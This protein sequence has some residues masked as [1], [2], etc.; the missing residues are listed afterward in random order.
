MGLSSLIKKSFQYQTTLPRA[1]SSKN[2]LGESW[3]LTT[4]LDTGR[5]GGIRKHDSG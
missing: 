3:M 2:D 1:C 4:R 5:E